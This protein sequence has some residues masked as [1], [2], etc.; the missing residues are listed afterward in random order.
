MKK[1]V[2]LTALCIFVCLLSGCFSKSSTSHP[3]TAFVESGEHYRLEVSAVSVDSGGDAAFYIDTDP[4]YQVVATDFGGDYQLIE[5]GGLT[6]L[7]LHNIY[8]PTRVKLTL[9]FSIRSIEY[10]ANGGGSLTGEGTI[11]TRYYDVSYHIRPNVSIGTDIFTRDGYTL[12][13]WNTE[14]DG[15][16]LQVGL[17]SRMT[18]DDTAVLYAQWAKWTDPAYF[19][20]EIKEGAAVITGYTEAGETLVIPETLG[21]CPV[22]T[23]STHA[24]DHSTAKT[25]ILPKTLKIIEENAFVGAALCELHF[26]DNI[27]YITDSCFSECPNFSQLFINA[28][29][30]PSGYSIRRESLLADKMDLMITTMGQ[31]RV[32]FYGGCAMWYNLIGTEAESILGDGVTVLNMGLNGVVSSLLQM[33]LMRHFVTENDVLVHAPEI[34]SSQQLILTTG[35]F[36]N[37][38][39]LWC[40]L[41]YNYDL[42]SMLDIRIFES[43]VLESFRQYLDKKKEGGSYTDIYHDSKGREYLDATGSIPYVRETS[44]ETLADKVVLDPAYLQ[45][46]S[47]LEQEYGYFT[48]KGVPVYVTYAC[49]NID[50]VPEEQRDRVEEMGQLFDERFSAMDGVTVIS[51]IRDYIYH[52]SDCF[53]TVYHLLTQ[54]AIEYTHTLLH[55]LVPW[56]TETGFLESGS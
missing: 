41:E 17:G 14:P 44:V 12:T 39:K 30:D 45:D 22:E 49:I 56:L 40:G 2:C 16:G 54:S 48:Q 47:R 35:L 46:L 37:D 43:G 13:G 19:T 28:I 50:Q 9:S 23:L 7:V 53:D 15:S 6:K 1:K 51:D 18:V 5:T 25:V 8:Y 20:Y 42:V 11:V 52:D 24:F 33:E 31:K 36:Q 26:F 34:A 55:D 32:I 21:G 10:R 3:I 4:G 29:E 38:T 27:E